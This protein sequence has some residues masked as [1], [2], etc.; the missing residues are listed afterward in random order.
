MRQDA[1]KDSATTRL[2][3]ENNADSAKPSGYTAD[4]QPFVTFF[5]FSVNISLQDNFSHGN[6]KCAGTCGNR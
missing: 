4:Q 6:D 3:A 5:C 2:R 1:E